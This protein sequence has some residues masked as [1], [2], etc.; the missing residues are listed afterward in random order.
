MSLGLFEIPV[1]QLVEP[2]RESRLIRG[3]DNVFVEKLKEKTM[4]DPSGPGATPMAMLCRDT[5]TMEQFNDKSLNLYKYEVLGGLHTLNMIYSPLR[6]SI[7][8]F[9]YC[10]ILPY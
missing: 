4:L 10:K 2:P 3:A 1:S 7:V 9:I 6:I 5:T 8:Y